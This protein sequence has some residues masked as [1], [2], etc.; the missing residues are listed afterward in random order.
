[1]PRWLTDKLTAYAATLPVNQSLLFPSRDG[2][3]SGKALNG[4]A[5][6]IA[7]DA[8]VKVPRTMSG[9]RQPF[10]G[11]RSY[12]A[13]KRLREGRTIYEV[14]EWIGW[15]DAD[16]MMRYLK[17][18]KGISEESRLALDATKEPEYDKENASDGKA[19]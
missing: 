6:R 12:A 3:P 11:F 18:A 7:K 19:A 9:E 2:R 1:M 8:G 14:M 16:T 4:L 13:I 17:K 5:N 15:D 10:H